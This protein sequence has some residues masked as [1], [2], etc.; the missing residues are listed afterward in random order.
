MPTN[1]P[2]HDPTAQNSLLME[3]LNK[4][5]REPSP[6]LKY[7]RAEVQVRNSYFSMVVTSGLAYLDRP[8]LPTD[9]GPPTEK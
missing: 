1:H 4:R 2:L 7:V 6:M 3:S 5:K 9:H 8:A